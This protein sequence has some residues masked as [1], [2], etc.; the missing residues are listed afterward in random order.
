MSQR[1]IGFTPGLWNQILALP[2]CIDLQARGHNHEG[3]IRRHIAIAVVLLH[4]ASD[5]HE[6]QPNP[7]YPDFRPP[8]QGNIQQGPWQT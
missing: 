6:E 2:T 4:A 1:G 3:L 7:W 8:E 5:R